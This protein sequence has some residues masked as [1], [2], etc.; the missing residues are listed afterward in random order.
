MKTH[1]LPGLRLLR[2]SRFVLAVAVAAALGGLAGTPVVS[3]L[4]APP[5]AQTPAPPQQPTDVEL[6]ISGD[7]GSPPRYAVP[8]FVAAAPDVAEAA[9]VIGPVLWDDL[10]FERDVA[11]IPRDI[12]STIA[13]ART[14]DQV[15]FAS[16]REVGAEAVVFGTVQRSGANMTVQVRLFNVASRRQVFA[17]EYTGPVANARQVAHNIADDIHKQQRNLRGVAR[18]KIAF[19]SDRT[20]E[21]VTGTVENRDVKEI[22]I[23][24]YDGAN[25][26][27]VTITR[28]MNGFPS[29]SP[30]GRA[31]T[32]SSWRKVATG[33]Q[34]D[35]YLS[36]IYQGLLEN[37]TKGVGGN[38]LSTFSPDGTRIAFMSTRDGNTE[39]YVANRDGSGIRRLTN[40]PAA[41][42]SP[43]WSPSGEQIAFT[44]DRTGQPQLYIMNADGSGSARRL[45]VPDGY[46]DKP[47]WAPAPFNEIAYTARVGGGFDIHIHSLS[48]GETRK[49]TFGEGANESPSYSANG[50]HIA[51][52]SS[53]SGRYQIFTIGRDGTGLRQITRD[54][55][56]ETPA[57]S[58]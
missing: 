48:T 9:K 44:S 52:S 8:D 23:A 43:T 31:L 41:D 4:Q 49:L 33:G 13:P 25:Q 3:G 29:W 37:P 51:F 50:R 20:R 7:G 22:W 14:A 45:P 34:V 2:P 17:Q 58:N 6:V 27:R 28:D 30:D 53:R 15:A 47:T 16:W 1:H 21:R 35:V 57:W 39:V 19:A 5:P 11:L 56:N 54:G 40:H 36:Y 38:Y 55:K 10:Q 42:S 46:A 24:D 12:A 32:Y 26:R 18:S